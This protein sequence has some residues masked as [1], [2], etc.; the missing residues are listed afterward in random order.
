MNLRKEYVFSLWGQR[1][2]SLFDYKK[3]EIPLKTSL[4]SEQQNRFRAGLP[5]KPPQTLQ[6]FY[7]ALNKALAQCRLCRQKGTLNPSGLKKALNQSCILNAGIAGKMSLVPC[8]RG[9]YKKR[10]P[11]AGKT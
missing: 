8:M 1:G 7:K 5:A 9:E 10:L 6:R 4:F 2:T 11:A 3:R